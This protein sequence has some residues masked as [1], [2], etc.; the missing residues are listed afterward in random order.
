[1]R[2]ILLEIEGFLSYK[3]RTIID[4]S[5]LSLFAITGMTGAGKTS[6]IDA[7]TFALYGKCPR[8]EKGASKE[9]YISK[10]KDFLR[11]S[12]TFSLRNKIYTVERSLRAGKNISLSFKE[13]G[14]EL[15]TEEKNKVREELL[16]KILDI[17]YETFTKIIVLPQGEF[18]KFIKPERPQERREIIIKLSNLDKID[19]IKELASSKKKDIQN[20]INVIN[21]KIESLKIGNEDLDELENTLKDFEKRLE[22]EKNVKHTLQD[23]LT[24]AVKKRELIK[25]LEKAKEEYE[26]LEEKKD[27]MSALKE[28]IDFIKPKLSLKSDIERYIKLKDNINHISQE[29]NTKHEKLQA[30]EQEYQKLLEAFKSIKQEYENTRE[31]ERRIEKGYEIVGKL[32]NTILLEDYINQRKLEI[33]KINQELYSLFS[34]LSNTS[35]KISQYESA[36]SKADYQDIEKKLEELT[37]TLNQ[38]EIKE[39]DMIKKSKDKER[40]L[41][42]ISTLEDNIN[43]YK[44]KLKIIEDDINAH[45]NEMILYHSSMLRT[46]LK[47][48]DICP[49]CGGIYQEKEHVISDSL[50]NIENLE[51]K[52]NILKEFEDLKHQIASSESILASKKEDLAK[53]IEEI[54]PLEKQL[55]NKKSIETSIKELKSK[56]EALDKTKELLQEEKLKKDK[57]ENLKALQENRKSDIEKEISAKEQEL[58]YKEEELISYG[59]TEEHLK[60]KKNT[61]VSFKQTIEKLKKDIQKAKEDYERYQKLLNNKEKERLVIQ[62]DILSLEKQTENINKELSE[63]DQKL[64]SLEDKE[65]I[66]EELKNLNIYEETYNEYTSKLNNLKGL[67]ESKKKE[68]DQIDENSTPEDLKENLN[69]VEESISN[70]NKEIG[71]I[72]SK[73][74]QIKEN[75]KKIKD[76]QKTLEELEGK[77]NVYERLEHDLKGDALQAYISQKIIE[78]LIKHANIYAS[79][80]DFPYT[81]KVE[82]APREKDSI[83][84]EDA[85]GNIRPVKSLS[86]GE[87]FITSLCF[88]LALSETIGSSYLQSLFI[89]E[90]FGTL[91]K[92]TLEKVGDALELLSQNIN[93]MVGIITHVESLAEKFTNR[94]IVTKTKDG[95]SKIEIV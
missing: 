77:L 7:I 5:E 55:L 26:V 46:L 93:K 62:T 13:N 52:N 61:V 42:E 3:E 16:Q 94:I 25:E 19:K 28:R 37:K 49:V 91:D 31:K 73:I 20:E 84:V 86:G 50:E 72:T 95:G 8:F 59:V 36:L 66:L 9:D 2:P 82:E 1:M 88:A 74:N 24:K 10:G 4:F 67:I 33:E 40:L 38:L 30:L 76:L 60:N 44:K 27:Q 29:L 56:K 32:E 85:F 15:R 53:L 17:D 65:N 21:S 6:I 83:V 41:K 78:E 64:S 87:T 14:K 71:S 43:K 54:E 57:L 70:L 48:N 63:L 68:I 47:E 69:V 81:F 75:E 79:K 35:E 45:K 39:Q 22:D 90:G 12:L 58:K 92:E 23:R 34:E 89:D 18:A 51:E 11:V 80:M